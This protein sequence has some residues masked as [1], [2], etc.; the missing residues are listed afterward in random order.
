MEHKFAEFHVAK[1][2]RSISFLSFARTKIGHRFSKKST[3]DEA[4]HGSVVTRTRNLPKRSRYPRNPMQRLHE[5]CAVFHHK[6]FPMLIRS[7]SNVRLWGNRPHYQQT[8]VKTWSKLTNRPRAVI[9]FEN[10]DRS[11]TEFENGGRNSILVEVTDQKV[12]KILPNIYLMKLY[13]E[14]NV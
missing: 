9:S 3:Y 12:T 13:V 7:H 6:I 1:T 8:M 4:V 14:V 2:I 5:H 11:Q 10:K